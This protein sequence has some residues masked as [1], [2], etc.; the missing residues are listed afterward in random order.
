[1]VGSMLF[2]LRHTDIARRE[3]SCRRQLAPGSSVVD[4][5]PN[6]PHNH[7][8]HLSAPGAAG[9]TKNVRRLSR[10]LLN[11]GQGDEP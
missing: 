8:L 4:M 10:V 1:M 5:Y 2:G 9:E 7:R 6:E 3:K 11:G